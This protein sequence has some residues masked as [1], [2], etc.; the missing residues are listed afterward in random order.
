MEISSF[1]KTYL[2]LSLVFFMQSLLVNAFASRRLFSPNSC[3]QRH[4]TST[5]ESASTSICL[6]IPEPSTCEEVGALIG[7]Y[8]RPPD[9]IFLDGDLGEFL[10]RP[11]GLVTIPSILTLITCLGAG[12]TTFSRGFI[13]CK[14]GVEEEDSDTIR[15][16]SPTYLLSNTYKY[17]ESFCEKNNEINE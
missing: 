5:L 15:V 6:S 12:K 4:V 11:K 2:C 8:S 10:S 14:L 16:T 13:H 3:L 17:H 7:A 1:H 9:A